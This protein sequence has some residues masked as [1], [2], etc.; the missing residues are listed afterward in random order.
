MTNPKGASDSSRDAQFA[1]SKKER[2]K[3]LARKSRQGF[4]NT[5][6]FMKLGWLE[7]P[8]R[9]VKIMFMGLGF[10]RNDA[11]KQK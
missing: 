10:S 1:P 11:T 7:S 8:T 6:S 2:I 9:S 4:A 5:S 3:K